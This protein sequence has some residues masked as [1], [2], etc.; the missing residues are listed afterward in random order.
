MFAFEI[1]DHGNNALIHSV[2]AEKFAEYGYEY[3]MPF[4]F[5]AIGEYAA[6]VEQAGFR[7]RYAVLFDGPTELKG[8]NGLKE[9]TICL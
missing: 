3:R 7:V 4:Y 9:W 8:S 1:G 6:L 5:S 2:L